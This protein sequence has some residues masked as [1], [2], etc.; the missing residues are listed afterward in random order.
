MSQPQA[1][2]SPDKAR[3]RTFWLSDELYERMRKRVG[4]FRQ[5]DGMSINRF[6]REAVEAALAK[7]AGR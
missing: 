3:K 2:P 7:K 5:A 6:V 1:T 4:G